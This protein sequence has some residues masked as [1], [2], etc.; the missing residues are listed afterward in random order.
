MT[1]DAYGLIQRRVLVTRSSARSIQEPLSS[2]MRDGQGNA[3]LDFSG[4]NGLTP[5]FLDELLSIVD[6]ARL[7]LHDREP[8]VTI[9]TPPMK[10]SPMF[11][12]VARVHGLKIDQTDGGDWVI[13][14]FPTPGGG[15]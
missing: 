7:V 9:K 10:I 14:R 6:E 12:A 4:V 3:E 2:A 13:S 15:L 5:S 1:I 8:S 11:E